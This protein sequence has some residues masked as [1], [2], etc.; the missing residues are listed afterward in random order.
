MRWWRF[1]R[2]ILMGGLCVLAFFAVLDVIFR[3]WGLL[4]ADA[5]V[6]LAVFFVFA[7]V[8]SR[9]RRLR[10]QPRWDPSRHPRT[11]LPR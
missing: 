6:A 7:F 11:P 4:A 10:K 2:R 1:W 8:S 9:I 3:D 5:G